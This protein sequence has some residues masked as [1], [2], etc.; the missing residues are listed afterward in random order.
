MQTLLLNYGYLM[1]GMVKVNTGKAMATIF[2]V[3]LTLFLT[4]IA[5]LALTAKDY[6]KT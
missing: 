1:K 2:K 5:Q 4:M 3:T 6:F